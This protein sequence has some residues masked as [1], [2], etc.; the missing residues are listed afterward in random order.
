MPI[1][2][3]AQNFETT[4]GVYTDVAGDY[5]SLNRSVTLSP[6]I[7]VDGSSGG[8]GGDSASHIT[9]N[10]GGQGELDPSVRSFLSRFACG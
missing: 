7:A 5:T 4:G 2:S 8:R 10:F 9:F 1:F 6:N 3:G